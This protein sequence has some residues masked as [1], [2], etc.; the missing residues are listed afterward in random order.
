M[1]IILDIC[2][3]R[4]IMGICSKQGGT[5]MPRSAKCR[6]VCQMPVHCRFAPEQPSR[7]EPLLLTVGE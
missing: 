6:R 5:P 3:K 2:P 4:F 1:R 7:E